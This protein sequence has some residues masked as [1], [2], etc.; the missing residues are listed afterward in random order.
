MNRESVTVYPDGLLD[1]PAA[2]EWLNV[3]EG[4]LRKKVSAGDVQCTRLGKHVRFDAD[5]L[6][7]IVADG[8]QPVWH[9]E[10]PARS[11]LRAPA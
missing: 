4:W 8:K 5:D 1:I 9:Y 10:Q 6:A 2:A 11:R 7:A 3:P